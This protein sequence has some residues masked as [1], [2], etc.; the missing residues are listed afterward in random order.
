M[1]GLKY[2]ATGLKIAFKEE[3]S[4]QSQIGFGI[5]A[6]LLSWYFAI[7]ATE[8]IFIVFMIGIVMAAELFNTAIEEVCDMVKAEQHPHVAK[9]KDLAAAAVL[10][11]SFTALLVGCII[12]IP[13][14]F[15]LW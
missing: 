15:A 13:Y 6:L 12:F 1:Q 8:F 5:F 3:L 10:V 4:F 14:I 7:S 11:S 2:A 9:I